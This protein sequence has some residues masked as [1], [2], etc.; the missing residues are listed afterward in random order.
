M[1]VLDSWAVGHAPKQAEAEE[2][3]LDATAYVGDA[4]D[5]EAVARMNTANLE[6]IG[7][8]V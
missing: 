8:G 1:A 5:E 4:Y 6:R 2:V 3:R 7:M